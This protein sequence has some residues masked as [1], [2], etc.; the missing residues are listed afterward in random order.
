MFQTKD[1]MSKDGID[2]NSDNRNEESIKLEELN[3][4][5]RLLKNLEVKLKPL[6]MPDHLD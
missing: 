6:Q 1:K 3:D 2:L 4:F 5:K